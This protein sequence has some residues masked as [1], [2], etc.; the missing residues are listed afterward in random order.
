MR[1][2]LGKDGSFGVDDPRPRPMQDGAKIGAGGIKVTVAEVPPGMT[3]TPR[4]YP[5]KIEGTAPRG[6]VLTDVVSMLE[7][8]F[9]GDP[10]F[11]LRH[12]QD[13]AVQ[14]LKERM[15]KRLESLKV[16][17][18]RAAQ[19]AADLEAKRAAYEAT[20][21][22]IKTEALKDIEEKRRRLEND[23]GEAETEASNLRQEIQELRGELAHEVQSAED[24]KKAVEAVQDRV[25]GSMG[26][27]SMDEP[28][29]SKE[30]A[31]EMADDLV[32][33]WR[34]LLDDPNEPMA[35]EYDD[36]A[37]M[38]AKLL[39]KTVGRV[40]DKWRDA[41]RPAPVVAQP[42]NKD[43]HGRSSGGGALF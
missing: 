21:E 1:K 35:A 11:N 38:L 30:K 16:M 23:I 27:D 15:E 7:A 14:R 37:A 36:L 32:H 17:E 41:G 4:R 8:R 9:Q 6:V 24:R 19:H 20:K 3:A 12:S 40:N 42:A 29:L 18:D 22:E 28:F 2:I 34:E 26:T 43:P 10:K 25:L 33:A 39:S 13:E 5:F 31:M